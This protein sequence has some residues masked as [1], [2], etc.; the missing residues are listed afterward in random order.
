MAF[1]A[2]VRNL[3]RFVH[4][5]INAVADIILDDTKVAFSEDFFN[6]ST[7]VANVSARLDLF[8]PFVERAFSDLNHFF[9]GG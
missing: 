8:N 2:I 6:G 3:G 5:L 9:D 7:N 4:T 1:F